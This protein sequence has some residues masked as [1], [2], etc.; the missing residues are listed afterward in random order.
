MLR[1]VIRVVATLL[2][3]VII[4]VIIVSVTGGTFWVGGGL[5]SC[6]ASLDQGDGP[7]PE[8]VQG[9]YEVS[10][11]VQAG[12]FVLEPAVTLRVEPDSVRVVA[13]RCRPESRR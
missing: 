8:V 10:V 9:G 13:E 1:R 3:F 7:V 5:A 11:L 4:G 6:P 12:N 2:V